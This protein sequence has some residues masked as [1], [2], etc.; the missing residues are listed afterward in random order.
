MKDQYDNSHCKHYNNTLIKK[1]E[2]NL[3][4]QYL[5]E[6]SLYL[7]INIAVECCRYRP[8]YIFQYHCMTNA[9]KEKIV[10]D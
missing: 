6:I 10:F 3:H 7:Q 8:Q 4:F 1:H 9:F 5:E 2:T